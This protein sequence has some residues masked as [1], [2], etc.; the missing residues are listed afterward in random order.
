GGGAGR[1]R[2]ATG[3]TAS[4]GA[5]GGPVPAA[6]VAVTVNVY[7]V[8]FVSPVTVTGLPAALACAPPGA[9]VTVYEPIGAPPVDAGAANVTVACPSPAAATTFVGGPGTLRC[10][11]GARSDAVSFVR[12][13]WA[14][15]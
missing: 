13:V 6:L 12:R 14:D 11:F 5:G 3:V 4:E 1:Q 7:A 15:P 9:A 2:A 10:Q 8:P